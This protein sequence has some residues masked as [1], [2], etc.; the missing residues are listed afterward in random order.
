MMTRRRAHRQVEKPTGDAP[1]KARSLRADDSRYCRKRPSRPPA[2]RPPDSAIPTSRKLAPPPKPKRDSNSP[3]SMPAPA[4]DAPASPREAV[5]AA[6]SGSESLRSIGETLA[7]GSIASS[8]AEPPLSP[9]AAVPRPR[10]QPHHCQPARPHCAAPRSLG[11]NEVSATGMLPAADK[12]RPYRLPSSSRAAARPRSPLAAPQASSRSAARVRKI[13]VRHRPARSAPAGGLSP[14]PPLTLISSGPRGPGEQS[15]RAAR[16]S[17]CRSARERSREVRPPPSR[18]RSL[19]ARASPLP[20]LPTLAVHTAGRVSARRR[21]A[22]ATTTARRR[23]AP[24][25]PSR[26][27]SRRSATSRA[28]GGQLRCASGAGV[29]APSWRKWTILRF[30]DCG[31]PRRRRAPRYPHHTDFYEDT[32][33][34]PK[35]CR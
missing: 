29:V 1:A 32:P 33:P 19:T 17:C 28:G 35:F 10:R 6:L 34:C 7:Q 5:A 16:R 21:R 15:R 25:A 30:S 24:P 8:A 22:R 9:R 14:T 26:H 11:S 4:S 23:A 18:A 20:S 2:L 31:L 3:G 12:G 27:R 13:A